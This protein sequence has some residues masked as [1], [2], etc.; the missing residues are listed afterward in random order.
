MSKVLTIKYFALLKDEAKK[1]TETFSTNARTA[2]ELF[3]ELS[4]TYGFSLK[5]EQ[6][7]VSINDEFKD[8]SEELTENDT[9][10]FIPPVAGG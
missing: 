10:V 2:E 1:D 5:P 3:I 4:K 9:I 7:R 6:I 8:L